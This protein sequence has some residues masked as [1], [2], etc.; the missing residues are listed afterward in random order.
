M[1]PECFTSHVQ[2]RF[3]R[4][5]PSYGVVE[6]QAR[7]QIRQRSRI[8]VSP[9]PRVRCSL[10]SRTSDNDGSADD[11]PMRVSPVGDGVV[12]PPA[13]P[14]TGLSPPRGTGLLNESVAVERAAAWRRASS[15]RPAFPQTLSRSD[16]VRNSIFQR[17]FLPGFVFQ[18]V[19][20]AGGYGT[21][22]WSS[23]FSCTVRSGDCSR[24]SSSRRSSGAPCAP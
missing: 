24:C 2:G 22:S 23:S 20:I 4:H 10:A 21:G 17:Y 3:H 1:P 13:P 19:V 12:R 14:G 15:V 5:D 11:D 16:V 8:D 18:S 9:T 6:K 7:C